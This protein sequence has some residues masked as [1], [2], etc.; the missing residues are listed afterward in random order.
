[1]YWLSDFT[2]NSI[3][4]NISN[5]ELHALEKRHGL[6]CLLQAADIAA[7]TWRRNPEERH[8][9]G[10]YLNTLCSSLLVPKWYVP[11]SERKKAA[12]R[13]HHR[14]KIVEAG[15]IVKAAWR[16]IGQNWWP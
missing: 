11:F 5:K 9:P 8:N 16:G 12:D 15:C 2:A 1:M 7:E 4:I 3:F 6:E 14:K 13:S 10:G